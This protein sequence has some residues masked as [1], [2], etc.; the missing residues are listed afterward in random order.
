VQQI[1]EMLW[2]VCSWWMDAH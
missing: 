2:P 1:I